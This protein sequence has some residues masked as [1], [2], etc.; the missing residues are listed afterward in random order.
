ML[1]ELK[2]YKGQVFLFCLCLLFSLGIFISVDSLRENVEDYVNQDSKILVGGDL[3]IDANT[4]YSDNLSIKLNELENRSINEGF[5]VSNILKFSSV[6]FSPK[7]NESILSQIKV[8]DSNHPLY[9]EIELT[10]GNKYSLQSNQVI[11]EPNLLEQLQIEIGDTLSIGNIDFTITDTIVSEPDS[12]LTLFSIGPKILLPKINIEETGLV[13]AKS[14]V[15]YITRFKT[16]DDSQME[17]LHSEIEPNLG[18]REDLDR[19]NEANSTLERFVINFL[20]FI[21]LISIF[22][23]FIT[24][25]GLTSTLTS[26]LGSV[27]QTIGIRKVLGTK[28]NSIVK[29]YISIVLLLGF[30]SFLLALLFAIIFMLAFPIVLGSI[31]P[32]DLIIGLSMFAILKG[33]ILALGIALLFTL[34]PIT[35]LKSISPIEIFKKEEQKK[36]SILSAT[37]FY[38]L[39][40]V[41]FALLIFLELESIERGIYI[42]LGITSLVVITFLFGYILLQ[43]IKY[44]GS[45]ISNISIKLAIKGLFRI[46]NKTL[47]II[48]SLSISLT[49]IFSLTFIEGNLQDQFITTFPENAPNLFIVDIPQDKY[50]EFNAFL[51]DRNHSTTIY[52]IIRAPVSSVNGIEIKEFSESLGEGEPVTREF[53]V[54]YTDKVASSEN[55]IKGDTLFLEEWNKEI[56]QVS[57][58]EEIATRMSLELGDTLVFLVQGVEIEAEV[59]SIRERV[60]EGIGAFFY[61]TFEREV[62]QDAPQTLFATLRVPSDNIN[63]LQNEIARTYP[64]ITVINGESTAKTIGDVIGQLSTITS[65]FTLFSLIGGILILISSILATHEERLKES[66]YYKLVGGNRSFI[67]KIFLAEYTILAMFSSLFALLFA[68]IISFSISEFLL[69]INFSFLIWE[70]LLYLGITMTTIIL[71]GYVSVLVVLKKKP[72]EYIRENNVE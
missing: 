66:I 16:Q 24:G 13:G 48:T 11:V 23:I 51:L 26:Y 2:F 7:S 31:L 10:S 9:G 45:K 49:L 39:I 61:F 55:L 22:I 36:Q 72:I 53:S 60:E 44:I 43:S 68:F 29:Y 38:F 50:D 57:V 33:F 12:A 8:V 54:T 3:L 35:R 59:V 21:K 18:E 27:K 30:V 41:F 4:A 6:V 34:Y 67:S 40:F 19:Y 63:Q 5:I 46:G 56:V 25:V 17:L 64:S 70:S 65:F 14:R 37:F 15:E 32:E 71:I 42:L 1:K 62:L 20:F 69:D 52:P 28:N 47:L 58:L